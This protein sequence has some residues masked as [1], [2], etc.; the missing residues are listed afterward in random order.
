[1]AMAGIGSILG[2]VKKA[3]G[4]SS[5][6]NTVAKSFWTIM[7]TMADIILMPMLPYM[8]K[9]LQW[10]MT[11]VM[12]WVLKVS[13]GVSSLLKGDLGPLYEIGY[14]LIW[15]VLRAAVGLILKSVRSYFF[16]TSHWKSVTRTT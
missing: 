3:F 9:F 15:D 7:G 16:N 2:I 13:E 11:S 8:F 4:S 5:I 14:K 10:M 6:L 12:P 1:M